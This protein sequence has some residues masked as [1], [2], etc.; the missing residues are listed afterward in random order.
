MR[1]RR[2]SARRRPHGRGAGLRERL[3]RA[4]APHGAGGAEVGVDRL[5][6][7][8]VVGVRV[9]VAAWIVGVVHARAEVR[10]VEGVW[11]TGIATRF[12]ND[13]LLTSAGV[14]L[15]VARF[16]ARFRRSRL[17]REATD[18]VAPV[19]GIDATTHWQCWLGVAVWLLNGGEYAQPP[20][21]VVKPDELPDLLAELELGGL[22]LAVASLIPPIGV[23]RRCTPMVDVA[24][25]PGWSAIG[26]KVIIDAARSGL[27]A[28]RPKR[29]ALR[30]GPPRGV[31]TIGGG[32][33]P[34][35][36]MRR[37]GDP[38]MLATPAGPGAGADTASLATPSCR[39]ETAGSVARV[40]VPAPTGSGRDSVPRT[41]ARD[42]H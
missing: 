32:P 8:V 12:V 14:A 11:L 18:G 31:Q 7:G 13:A 1:V 38:T 25:A 37:P 2:W 26:A 36:G 23:A 42:D 6:L 17:L 24:K 10:A 41:G 4:H 3:G 16:A 15:D 40:A 28:S 27:S 39:R 29:W 20:R 5:E 9:L 30:P 33:L 19:D 21:P 35:P 22:R 34:R